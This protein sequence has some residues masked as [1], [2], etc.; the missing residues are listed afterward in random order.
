MKI[1]LRLLGGLAA[2]ILALVLIAYLLPRHYRVERSIVVHAPA[3]AL[4]PRAG[5]MREWKQWMVWHRRD[6]EIRNTYSADQL[7]VGAWAAWDSKK[8]GR[9]KA[10]VTALEPGRRLVYH[11]EFPDFGTQST[12]TILLVPEGGGTRVVWSDEG[13]LGFNPMNRWFGLFLDGM[14]GGD[15]EASLAAL[16]LVAE[17]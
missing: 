8:E 3:A 7:Q 10:T 14:L 6:P 13:D 9:G 16:K 2:L 5:D 11:L 1:L 12:G 4:Y 17:K 15:F